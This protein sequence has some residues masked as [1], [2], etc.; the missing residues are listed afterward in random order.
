LISGRR[1][2]GYVR[3]ASGDVLGYQVRWKLAGKNSDLKRALDAYLD[4]LRRDARKLKTP[5]KC[6][7]ETEGERLV[8]RWHGA[9]NGYGA[10][11]EQAG[12]TFFVEASSISNKSARSHF[13]GLDESFEVPESNLERW[14]LFGLDVN[15]RA[16]L[17]VEK[18]LFQSG[19]TRIEL[20]SGSGLVIAERWGFGAQILEKHS[21]SDWARESLAMPKALVRECDNGIELESGKYL[22]KSFALARF[23]IANNQI[24]TL[25]TVGRGNKEKPGWDWLN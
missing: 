16:G 14:S 15:L 3:I 6:D 25:K 17:A 20:K 9:G 8:Y 13:Q 5:F 7:A 18:H 19:R 21:F 12:R 24:V 1:D 2:E 4:R 11:F 23:D 22:S 10:L